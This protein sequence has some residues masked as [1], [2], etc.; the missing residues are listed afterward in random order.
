MAYWLIWLSVSGGTSLFEESN[1]YETV[2]GNL[3]WHHT[4]NKAVDKQTNRNLNK[5]VL[6]MHF[7]FV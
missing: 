6:S 1:E 5:N 3:D 7:L 4:M 2:I